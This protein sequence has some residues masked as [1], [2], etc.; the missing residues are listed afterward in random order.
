MCETLYINQM[1]FKH[2]I[3]CEDWIGIG[4]CIGPLLCEDEPANIKETWGLTNFQTLSNMVCF[5][6][7][8]WSQSSQHGGCWCLTPSWHQGTCNHRYGTDRLVNIRITTV[9]CSMLT[10]RLNPILHNETLTL[11]DQV[12]FELKFIFHRIPCVTKNSSH[13]D[14]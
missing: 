14:N 6:L 10:Q 12:C 4:R 13:S 5:N 7:R 1:C 2:V 8:V 11:D 3:M 9:Y